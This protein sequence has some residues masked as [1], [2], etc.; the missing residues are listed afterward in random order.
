[1]KVPLY[2]IKQLNQWQLFQLVEDC[3][4]YAYKFGEDMP[5][6][7]HE[8]RVLL[9]A[10][11][12]VYDEVIAESTRISASRVIEL[13]DKRNYILR[14]MFQVIST[15]AD[16]NFSPE[17]QNASR[18]LSKLLKYYGSGRG[19]S[20]M[21][22][23]PKS[24]VITNMIQDL[25]KEQS[26]SQLAALDLTEVISI[27]S[28]TNKDFNYQSH[29][30]ITEQSNFVTGVAKSARDELQKQFLEFTALINALA[31]VESEEKYLP[32]KKSIAAAV[33]KHVA[34]ARQRIRKKEEGEVESLDSD[35]I[36]PPLI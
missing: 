29:L 20:R 9:Q 35:T 23:Q 34:Q 30:R 18:E 24:A 26:P 36:D 5:S 32:L 25:A 16:Y 22:Q 28:Q 2:A 1:M 4:T 11:F 33:K 7:Y 27:L 21:N 17:K 13:D 15:Y 8:K 14:K 19:I 12:D 6:S 3:L 10:A 31:V